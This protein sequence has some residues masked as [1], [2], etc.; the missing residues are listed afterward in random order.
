MP[1]RL[2]T[3]LDD[4]RSVGKLFERNAITHSYWKPDLPKR[5]ELGPVAR[6]CHNR[7][8]GIEEC[9]KDCR[10]TPTAR[11]DEQHQPGAGVPYPEFRIAV[12]LEFEAQ[13]VLGASIDLKI[14]ARH[15]AWRPQGTEG[16]GTEGPV[17]RISAMLLVPPRFGPKLCG[18]PAGK[19]ESGEEAVDLELV[20]EPLA[21]GEFADPVVADAKLLVLDVS[22]GR[23]EFEAELSDHVVVGG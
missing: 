5:I 13:G 18:S 10:L 23:D 20:L 8:S 9:A 2:S 4:P 6:A 21:L 7:D 1:S 11:E 17:G 14:E 3:R 16:V 15:S 12:E 22:L 19:C